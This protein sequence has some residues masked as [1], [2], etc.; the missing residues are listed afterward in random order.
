VTNLKEKLFEL[1]EKEKSNQA[2]YDTLKLVGITEK[3]EDA[4]RFLAEYK[5]WKQIK[6]SK[7]K[8]LREH[9][10]NNTNI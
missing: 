1:Y 3:G 7:V 5:V 10:K 6:T 8:S 4:K 2:L 9:E